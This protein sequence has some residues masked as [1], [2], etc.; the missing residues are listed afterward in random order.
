MSQ[1]KYIYIYIY[2]YIKLN[3]N[4]KIK[5]YSTYPESRNPNKDFKIKTFKEKLNKYSKQK[6]VV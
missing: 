4:H 2:I 6:Q 5:P 1:V 3:K